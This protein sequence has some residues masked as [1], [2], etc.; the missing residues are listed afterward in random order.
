MLRTAA[1]TLLLAAAAVASDAPA[2]PATT[3]APA[4]TTAP[5]VT[6]AIVPADHLKGLARLARQGLIAGGM[7]LAPADISTFGAAIGT[8]ES[9]KADGNGLVRVPV[10]ALKLGLTRA[11]QGLAAVVEKMTAAEIAGAGEI[12]RAVEE[13]LT[14]SEKPAPAPAPEKK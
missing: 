11:R 12:I 5:V 13:S 14:A 8:I 6:E 9:A 7:R 4:A 2:A 1:I 10:D 3:P